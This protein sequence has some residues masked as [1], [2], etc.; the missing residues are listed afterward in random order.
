MINNQRVVLVTGASAG[1]GKC[2][3]DY[4]TLEGN[5]VYGTSRRANSTDSEQRSSKRNLFRLIQMDVTNDSSVKKGIDSIIARESRLDAVVNNAGYAIIGSLED[6]TVKEAKSQLETNFFG[7]LR[8]CRAVL[9]IMRRQRTGYI[10]NISSIGGLIGLPFQSAYCA[11][12]FALEG[13][14]EALRIEVRPFGIH[15]VLIEPGDF[16][17]EITQHRQLAVA[18]KRNSAYRDIFN[19][20]LRTVESGERNGP[21]PELVAELINNVISTKSPRLRYTV[22][23]ISQRIAVPLKKILPSRLFESLISGS[24]QAS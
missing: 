24:F 4:L 21:T 10:V 23:N 13:A 7:A 16:K 19:R 1:I 22:G 5:R 15:V 3:A 8:V 12:K 9:P 6:T 2:C 14:M 18:S 20:V 11:S 17:T